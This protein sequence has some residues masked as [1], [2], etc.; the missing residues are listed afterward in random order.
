MRR[1]FGD[2]CGDGGFPAAGDWRR[3]R[4][5]SFGAC[6]RYEE[7]ESG[8]AEGVA[9]RSDGTD[10]GGAGDFPA[11]PD[12]RELCLVGCG[13]CG[14]QCLCGDGRDRGG[15]GAVMRVAPRREGY[16]GFRGQGAGRAGGAGGRGWA[17]VMATSPD[18]KVY[19]LGECGGGDGSG[20]AVVFDPA[21]T[22][23]KP[24]Y[25][26]D[27]VGELGRSA[28]CGGWGAGGGVS[29]A[30]GWGARRRL[31]SLRLFKTADQH[32]RCLLVAPDGTL[33]AGSDGAG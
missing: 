21:Q 29:G 24:K 4:G 1:V 31:V 20:A 6:D 33:W 30:G 16:Q 9:I 11:L 25:L 26:W 15:F 17:G 22:E 3:R 2:W 32:I 5:P 8:T 28:I 13:G 19:R 12:G 14:G 23:E 18:G 7:M 10:G 27:V